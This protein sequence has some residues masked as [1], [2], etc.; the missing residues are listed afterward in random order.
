MLPALVMAVAIQTTFL[1]EVHQEI[2]P[3]PYDSTSHSRARSGLGVMVFSACGVCG[4]CL[5]LVTTLVMNCVLLA[6]GVKAPS[7][8]KLSNMLM[9]ILY[10]AQLLIIFALVSNCLNLIPQVT[11]R[12]RALAAAKRHVAPCGAFALPSPQTARRVVG[13]CISRRVSL[14]LC[15]CTPLRPVAQAHRRLAIFRA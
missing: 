12:A 2:R 10:F 14:S 7:I 5:T 1:L 3:D 4:A 8:P 11:A 15:V 13:S 9:R 6:Q